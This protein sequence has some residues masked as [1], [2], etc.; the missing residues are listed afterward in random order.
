[1]PAD[2]ITRLSVTRAAA[3]NYVQAAG[4]A[5]RTRQDP[6]FIDR[7]RIIF[8]TRPEKRRRNSAG[9]GSLHGKNA[10]V[11]G[12][13]TTEKDEISASRADGILMPY[14][15]TM[16]RFVIPSRSRYSKRWQ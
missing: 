5:R 2:Y 13:E 16:R 8:T 11:C 4:T 15:P 7:C 6:A 14:R 3:R 12:K 10:R 9:V 1:M